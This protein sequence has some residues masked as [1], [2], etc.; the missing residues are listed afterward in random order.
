MRA[1]PSISMQYCGLTRPPVPCAAQVRQYALTSSAKRVD[2]C[3]VLCC[4]MSGQSDDPLESERAKVEE[5]KMRRPLP[6]DAVVGWVLAGRGGWKPV[7]TLCCC[8]VVTWCC[9]MHVYYCQFALTLP[10]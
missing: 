8:C 2:M 3:V 9:S 5:P 6:R 7:R 4:A 1:T 10:P